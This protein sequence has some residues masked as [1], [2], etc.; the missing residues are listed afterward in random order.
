M[1]PGKYIGQFFTEKVEIYEG[2][3]SGI[4]RCK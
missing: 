1:A 3:A 2:E 4:L